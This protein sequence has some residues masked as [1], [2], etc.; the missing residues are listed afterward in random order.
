MKCIAQCIEYKHIT[1]YDSELAIDRGDKLED[2]E[3]TSK[4]MEEQAS[5]FNRDSRKL[6]RQLIHL[7]FIIMTQ[8]QQA[9]KH[10]NIPA[11]VVKNGE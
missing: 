6:R 8:I 9:P 3:E 5:I 2:L 10:K 4:R 7:Y 1:I 11:S